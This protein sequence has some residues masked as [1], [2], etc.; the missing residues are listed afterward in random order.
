M[1]SFIQAC[2]SI[3]TQMCSSTNEHSVP[4]VAQGQEKGDT[5]IR[6]TKLCKM[7]SAYLRGTSIQSILLP[8]L[9]KLF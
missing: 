8:C 3:I 5:A 4:A 6:E 9:V 7:I 1:L 2:F